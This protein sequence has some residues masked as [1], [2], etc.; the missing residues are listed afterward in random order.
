M[1]ASVLAARTARE[2]R[3]ESASRP[4]AWTD[5]PSAARWVRRLGVRRPARN[6]LADPGDFSRRARGSAAVVGR[7][8]AWRPRRRALEPL[9]ADPRRGRGLAADALPRTFL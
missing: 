2:C 5:S 9:V 4:C 3:S 1:T 6:R 8:L 7:G